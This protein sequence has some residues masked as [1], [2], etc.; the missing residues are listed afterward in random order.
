MEPVVDRFLALFTEVDLHPPAIPYLSNVTGGWITAEQATD[1]AYW[2]DHLRG[3]VRFAAAVG[4]LWREPGRV[5]LEVGPGQTLSSWA[6]Q[7]PATAGV[8]A[9]VALPTL[10]HAFDRTDDLAFLL[11]SVG[12]LWLTGVRLDWSAFWAGRPRRRVPLPTYPFE[13]RRYWIEPCPEPSPEPVTAWAPPVAAARPAAA[14]LPAEAPTAAAS[15]PSRRQHPRPNLHVAYAP[16]RDETERRLVE[17]LGEVLRL[18]TVG[19]HDGFFDLGGD[20][21]LATHLLSRLN[22]ELGVELTLRTFFAA[23]TVAGLAAEIERLRQPDGAPLRPSIV[24]FR[25]DRGSPPPLT[26]AQERF[27]AARQLEAR[28]VASTV[29]VLVRFEGRLDPACL[30]RA[31]QEIVDRHEVLRTSF[32]EDAEGPVQVVHPTIPVR[33]PLVDLE[34][35]APPGRRAE[36]QRWSILDGRSH[37]EYD[38]APLFRVTLFRCAEREH[39]L[40]FTVHHIAFDGWSQAVLFRELSVLYDA[41]REGRPSPLPPLVAQY[42]DFARWQRQ[43]LQGETLAQEVSFWREHLRDATPVRLGGDRPPP[44]HPTFDAGIELVQIPRELQQQLEA[45]AAEHFVTLS[46]TLFAAFQVLL[47]QESGRDDIVVTC[48]FGNR[49][50]L[51]TEELIGNF[52]AGLPL[53]TRLSGVRTFRDLLERVR[54]VML[55]AHEHPDILYEPVMEDQ[56]YLR[57]GDRG[58]LSTF[59]IM[60]QLTKFPPA[61]RTLPDLEIVGLPFDTGKIG[62]DLTLFLTQSDQLAGRFKYNRDVLDRERVTRMRERFI[63]ILASVVAGADC[64][65]TELVQEGTE[66]AS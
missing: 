2:A 22:H 51:E 40:L 47:H 19:L 37:F 9:P 66:V 30:L 32:G 24:S 50:E 64:P 18:E 8:A 54:D 57:N 25:Q 45:F 65:L 34:P 55:A 62:Q 61:E 16:P 28:T 1:P 31:L 42:Q 5:L 52:I 29:P 14:P 23:P 12:R 46:M 3:T 35:V 38:R 56:V 60:F 63:R 36:V 11:Q 39:V 13:R 17:I 26:F 33:L 48:L 44:A 43:R 21:L 49:N 41:F 4:E 20:S 15:P 58:G 53:R 10:R 59:R 6:L 7:H 27:W